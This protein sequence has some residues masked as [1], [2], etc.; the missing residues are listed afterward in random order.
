MLG[1]FHMQTVPLFIK[2]QTTS[3]IESMAAVV[4]ER[5]HLWTQVNGLKINID[6]T[7]CILFRPWNRK[8]SLT[9]N[10]TMNSS[11]LEIA[12]Y[13]VS[14]LLNHFFGLNMLSIPIE[15]FAK[16]EE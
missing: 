13:L 16:R 12:K 10:I 7:K 15:K 2:G 9:L 11:F 4:L 1:L 8:T 14:F 6:K 3:K 5:L